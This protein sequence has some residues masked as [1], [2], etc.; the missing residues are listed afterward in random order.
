MCSTIA[1]SL[2]WG[3]NASAR[4]HGSGATPRYQRRPVAALATE[5][6]EQLPL[7]LTIGEQAQRVEHHDNRATLVKVTA[8]GRLTRPAKVAMISSPIT[9]SEIARFCLITARLARL[10]PTAKGSLPR[11]SPISATSAVSS[12]TAVPT[13]PIAM[14]TVALAER[15]GVDYRANLLPEDK[16]VVVKAYQAQGRTVVMVGDGVND[17]PALAQADV[18]IAMGAAG[19]AIALEAAHIALMREDWMLVPEVLQIAQRTMRVVKTNIAFTAVYNL[20]GLSLAAFGVLPPVLAAAAQSLPD[21]G[22]LANASR[23]LRQGPKGD[24]LALNRSHR[25][26]SSDVLPVGS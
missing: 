20:V 22:I 10:R 12:A 17:A 9:P 23:L 5:V 8:I 16:I 14:L 15:L 7:R 3:K 25:R 13:P 2:C 18:G 19:T 11:S 1:Q 21:L 4:E 24:T 26:A 6:A